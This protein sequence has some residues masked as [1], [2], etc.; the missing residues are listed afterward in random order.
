MSQSCL[1][2]VSEE[3]AFIWVR[4]RLEDAA[5]QYGLSDPFDGLEHIIDETF[6]RPASDQ[7]Y[8]SNRLQPGALPMEWSFSED[9]PD[10]LRIEIQPFDA[11]LAPCDRTRRLITELLPFLRRRFGVA[12]ADG[13]LSTVQQY[14]PAGGPS[15]FGAFLGFAAHPRR[16]LR[17][18]V[19]LEI[20]DG[21][22]AR[23]TPWPEVAGLIPHFRSIAASEDHLS[24]RVYY[25][26]TEGLSLGSL[27]QVCSGLGMAH[28]FPSLLMTVLQFTDGEFFLP[29]KSALLGIRHSRSEAELK[30]ELVVGNAAA[31]QGLMTRIERMLQPGVAAA[32]RRWAVLSGVAASV[33]PRLSVVSIRVSPAQAAR[34]S[35]YA[36]DPWVIQ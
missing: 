19:Y 18:K 11:A 13:F 10:S 21:D 29:P 31:P 17:M 14:G 5:R 6:T 9:E 28:R 8:A 27:E 1:A 15:G 2:T 35:V 23:K 4:G 12:V 7:A 16:P 36:S 20:A 33:N 3:P 34:L 30:I 32:F 24:E 26:A 22:R 25:I